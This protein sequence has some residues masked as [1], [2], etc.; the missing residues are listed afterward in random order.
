[1]LLKMRQ[2]EIGKGRMSL[3]GQPIGM[4]CLPTLLKLEQSLSSRGLPNETYSVAKSAA[5]EWFLRMKNEYGITSLKE[6]TKWSSTIISLA[7]WG[8][9]SV[10]SLDLEKKRALLDFSDSSF[11]KAHGHSEHPV[12]NLVRGYTAGQYQVILGTEVESVETRC[13]AKGDPVC[14]FLIQP[15]ESFDLKDPEVKRQL[16]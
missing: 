12:D 8:N 6:L 1:M 10:K 13:N 5:E 14:Q 16:P 3:L 2:M 4:I 7:G 15:K 11:A 9:L